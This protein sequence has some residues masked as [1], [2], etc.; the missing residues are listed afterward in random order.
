M[1][2]VTYRN[3]SCPRIFCFSSLTVN[4]IQIGRCGHVHRQIHIYVYVQINPPGT[5]R[6]A[7]K[8]SNVPFIGMED[9]AMRR[10]LMLNQHRVQLCSNSESCTALHSLLFHPSARLCLMHSFL[11]DFRVYS[12]FHMKGRVNDY[13]V[14]LFQSPGN[15]C[16]SYPKQ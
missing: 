7:S 10:S 5:S 2:H 3:K 6:Q 1:T 12:K 4:E 16:F 15:F 11:W 9:G 13:T 8:I 14:E